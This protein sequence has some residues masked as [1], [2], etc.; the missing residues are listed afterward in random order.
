[1]LLRNGILAFGF[2]A[3]FA[4]STFYPAA[5][6]NIF[7]QQF[8]SAAEPDGCVGFNQAAL[9]EDVLIL[10]NRERAAAGL[11]PLRRDARL[12]AAARGHSQDMAAR[13][14]F[15]HRDPEGNRMTERATAAGYPWT[16]LAENIARGQ[17]S[18][19]QVMAS[20]MSSDVGHRENIFD[21]AYCDIGV[22]V[23]AAQASDCRLHWTQNFGRQAG[24][25][26]CGG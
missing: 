4:A 7:G 17:L 20:W 9:E 14:Y 10:V 15:D 6:D 19:A 12:A 5:A 18:A 26:S 23:G 21:G 2:V 8:E 3:L 25:V 24:D 22:G 16:R 11:A 13:G 1:M